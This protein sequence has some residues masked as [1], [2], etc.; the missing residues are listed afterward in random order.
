MHSLG[1]PDECHDEINRLRLEC[2]E[3]YQVIGALSMYAGVFEHPDVIRALDNLHAAA[4][5]HARP[6]AEILPWPKTPL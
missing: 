6:H 5:G 4:M 2:A 1:C 3:A